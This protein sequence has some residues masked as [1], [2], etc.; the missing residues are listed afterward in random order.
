MYSQIEARDI[1]IYTFEL[2]TP[3]DIS[4]DLSSQFAEH[5]HTVLLFRQ[6]FADKAFM[7]QIGSNYMS[8]S[9]NLIHHSDPLY[10]QFYTLAIVLLQFRLTA[11]NFAVRS[12][13]IVFFDRS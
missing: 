10:G 7:D 8:K 6:S 11:L 2:R 5:L 13:T 1:N 4:K 3:I 12:G 9:E